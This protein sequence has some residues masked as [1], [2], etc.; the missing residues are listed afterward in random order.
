MMSYKSR[1]I[2]EKLCAFQLFSVCRHSQIFINLKVDLTEISYSHAPK[3]DVALKTQYR[4]NRRHYSCTVLTPVGVLAFTVVEDY[5]DG[6]VF[7]SFLENEVANAIHPRITCL[8]DN[9]AIHHTPMVRY[10]P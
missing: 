6:A 1:G 4:M 5:T 7:Q 8:L 9:A 10:Y 2:Y 3:G